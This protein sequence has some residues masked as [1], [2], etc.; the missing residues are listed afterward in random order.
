MADWWYAKNGERQGPVTSAQ[1]RQ[2]AESG[3]LLPTDMV[4]KEG[5]S[6][7]KLASTVQNLKFPAAGG[8]VKSERP[9]REER[10]AGGL[11]FDDRPSPGEERTSRRRPRESSGESSGGFKDLL[12]FRR[13]IAPTI[14]M[15]V[16]WMSV[17]GVCLGGLGALVAGMVFIGG[18]M[19]IIGGLVGLIIGVPLSLL[20]IR[21]YAELAILLFRMN[22]TLTDIKN[23]LDKDQRSKS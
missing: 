6:E 14:I 18:P 15:V 10:A 1:L 21:L 4:F 5:G 23:L 7:W 8:A 20:V 12:M 13:M 16:F 17:I 22:E 2:L 19:G 3:V 11:D 9:A